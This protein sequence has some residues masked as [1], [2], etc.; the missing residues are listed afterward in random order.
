MNYYH[1][2]IIKGIKQAAP[3]RQNVGK[4]FDRQQGREETPTEWLEGLWKNMQQ[5]SGIDPNSIMGQ[6]LIRI[7]F[8]THAWPY[9]RK[10]LEKIEDWQDKGLNELLKEA[11]KVY[12]WRDEEK[13]KVKA[14]I[15]IAR[16]YDRE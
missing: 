8:T 14:K 2:L 7:N 1:N 5:Y 9:I 13:A 3:Q 11:Q 6:S 4:A 10:K 15:M 12:A 16:D